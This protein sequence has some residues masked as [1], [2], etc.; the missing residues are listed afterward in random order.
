MADLAAQLDVIEKISTHAQKV[1]EFKKL[2]ERLFAAPDIGQLTHFLARLSEDPPP[3][4]EAVPTMISR[5][6]LQDFTVLLFAPGVGL[7]RAQVNLS[8]SRRNT[9]T[10]TSNISRFSLH[11]QDGMYFDPIHACYS[12]SH[13]RKTRK[14]NV[15]AVYT[16][17]KAH[18][19]KPRGYTQLHSCIRTDI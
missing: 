9:H 17:H 5:Q 2:A 7:S 10:Q 11:M 15:C 8:P 13:T 3:Q 12:I 19:Y 1:E 18:S 16:L 4:G 6:V 14:L